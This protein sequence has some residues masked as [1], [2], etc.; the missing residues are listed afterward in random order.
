V[1]AGTGI[2]HDSSVAEKS[3]S[4]DCGVASTV[5]EAISWRT[6]FGVI[7]QARPSTRRQLGCGSS[8]PSWRALIAAL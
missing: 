2:A 8:W 7:V 1:Q 6:S 5:P 4:S 3:T